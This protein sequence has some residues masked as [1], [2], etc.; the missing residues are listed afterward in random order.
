MELRPSLK[1]LIR[2]SIK[3][4]AQSQKN[5]FLGFYGHV[6]LIC[7]RY[8]RSNQIA[9]ECANDT[10]LKVFR[11][12]QKYDFDYSFKSWISR[13]AV[14]TCIDSIRKEEKYTKLIELVDHNDDIKIDTD[15]E[16]YFDIIVDKEI[17]PIIQEL[18]PSYRMVFNLFVFE[19]YKHREIAEMLNISTG[20]SKSNYLRAKTIIKNNILHNEKYAELKSKM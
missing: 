4:D 1:S 9:E 20:T 6:L 8:N 19:G 12:L 14:N 15:S 10:F 17:L 18:S 5:L 16:L 7:K 11:N 13:I 2:A 3:G